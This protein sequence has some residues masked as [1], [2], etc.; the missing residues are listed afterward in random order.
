MQC[1][2]DHLQPL[3]ILPLGMAIFVVFVRQRSCLSPCQSGSHLHPSSQIITNVKP[4]MEK[5]IQV[6][7]LAKPSAYTLHK[8]IHDRSSSYTKSEFP[9]LSSPYAISVVSLHPFTQKSFLWE[10]KRIRI[11]S[12]LK[13]SPFCVTAQYWVSTLSEGG[14]PQRTVLCRD[15]TGNLLH[16]QVPGYN[17]GD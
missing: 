8:E 7:L 16:V 6:S 11:L 4:L 2:Q 17:A 14:Q 9:K 12:P 3:G 15:A 13:E 1:Q 10:Q 5:V